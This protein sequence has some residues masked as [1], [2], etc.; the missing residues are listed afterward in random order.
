MKKYLIVNG[1]DFGASQGINRGIVE[2]HRHGILTSASLMIDMPGAEEAAELSRELPRMS[3]GIHVTISGEDFLPL[4]DFDSPDQCRIEL[5]RQLD[6]FENLMEKMPTHIDAHHNIYR[7]PR[8]EPYFVEISNQ[9][10]CLCA[11]TRR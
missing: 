2:A 11:N 8:V 1:D 5:A 10:N 7:D 9:T 4:I 6:V 3:V